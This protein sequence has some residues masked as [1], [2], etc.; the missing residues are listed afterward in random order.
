MPANGERRIAVG[1][2]SKN[3]KGKAYLAEMNAAMETKTEA[4]KKKKLKYGV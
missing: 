2:M 4:K 3:S 1:K